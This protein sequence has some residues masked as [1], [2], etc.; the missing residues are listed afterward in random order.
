MEQMFGDNFFQETGGSFASPNRENQQNFVQLWQELPNNASGLII[1][2][3]I[4]AVFVYVG[5]Q[6]ILILM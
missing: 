5:Y 1:K 2:A 4:I 3:L 6:T